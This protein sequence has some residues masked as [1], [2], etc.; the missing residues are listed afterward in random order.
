MSIGYFGKETI[1]SQYLGENINYVYVDIFNPNT[2]NNIKGL[3]S[4]FMYIPKKPNT[5]EMTKKF[6]LY[7]AD[8]DIKHIV[9]LGSLGPYRLIHQQL[10]AFGKEA[11]LKI[12]TLA[13]APL[14]NAIFY[15]QYCDKELY[16][17]RY[18]GQAPYLDPEALAHVIK[19]TL[20]S[21]Y[22]YNDLLEITG[23]D[24]YTIYDISMYM[25]DAGYEVVS[26]KDIEYSKTHDIDSRDADEI[27]L[28]RLGSEYMW[29]SPEKT[30]TV[31]VMFNYAGR[32]FAKFLAD[33]RDKV[34]MRFEEDKWL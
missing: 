31:K 9:K 29:F 23:D 28:A 7:C 16:D 15:E 22:P 12:T 10:D 32:S 17:Y 8:N 20:N 33:D 4:L 19:Y 34:D 25:E 2:W 1:L 14:M 11:G 30:N 24:Q 3:T 18:G 21:D 27:L 26:I 6:F 13:I 5:V